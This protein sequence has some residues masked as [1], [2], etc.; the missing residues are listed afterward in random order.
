MIRTRPPEA[1]RRVW[2]RV[3]VKLMALAGLAVVGL[4]LLSSLFSTEA[5]RI[6]PLALDLRSLAPGE[7]RFDHWNRRRVLVLHRTPDMLRT[8]QNGDGLLDPESKRSRQPDAARNPHRSLR[9]EYFVA[10][11]HGTDLGCELEFVP[12]G[13]PH[14]GWPG[15]FRDRCRGSRYDFAGRVYEGQEAYR[16]LEIP[17]HRYLPDGR[18]LIGE[19]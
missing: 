9:P 5:E 8:V 10:I 1:P 14:G 18:L 17:P 16:N 13:D 7:I 15:G 12:Q 19:P 6:E 11:A 3:P 4:V 2:L